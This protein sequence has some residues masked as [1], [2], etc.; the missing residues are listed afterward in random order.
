LEGS[1]MRWLK[2]LAAATGLLI[3]LIGVPAGLLVAVGNPWPNEGLDLA[4]PLT[5]NAVI[6][7]LAAA[8]WVLW[9]QW[10]VCVVVES[11]STVRARH[12]DLVVPATFTVQQ[13]LARILVG[14][15]AVVF[16]AGPT[17]SNAATAQAAGADSGMSTTM[18]LLADSRSTDQETGQRGDKTVGQTAS[19]HTPAHPTVTVGRGDTLWALAAT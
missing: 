17:I 19:Q 5:D 18:S 8:G 4:A 3:G 15:I 12:R 14:A 6:G 10:A 16:M 13:Q 2:A 7:L 11:I 9:A 1:H